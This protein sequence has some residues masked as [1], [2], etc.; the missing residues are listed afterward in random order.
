MTHPI[1]SK[2]AQLRRAAGMTQ[3]DLAHE[4][5]WSSALLSK[6]ETGKLEPRPAQIDHMARA[7]KVRV[8][9]TVEP[10]A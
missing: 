5:G 2:I 7:L 9:W 8:S 10:V 1:V 4:C 3:E 6:W